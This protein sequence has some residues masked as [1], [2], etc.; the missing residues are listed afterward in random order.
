V[1]DD[2]DPWCK[3]YLTETVRGRRIRRRCPVRLDQALIDAGD[4]THP[5][6]LPREQWGDLTG[7]PPPADL[8]TRR[9]AR[10]HLRNPAPA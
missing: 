10:V 3:G 2:P 7:A 4:D 6:C 9:P 8:T 5:M 1:A